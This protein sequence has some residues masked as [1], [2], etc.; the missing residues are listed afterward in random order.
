MFKMLKGNE[1]FVKI[2]YNAVLLQF[3]EIVENERGI[4]GR[5]LSR[6][7]FNIY[8]KKDK[9]NLVKIRFTIYL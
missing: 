8:I 2:K 1:K 7:Y 5:T 9:K 6:H 4:V 3:H